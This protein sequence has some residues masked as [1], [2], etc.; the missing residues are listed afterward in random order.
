MRARR[1]LQNA[2]KV[3]IANSVRYIRHAKALAQAAKDGIRLFME[4]SWASIPE[5]LSELVPRPFIRFDFVRN[6]DGGLARAGNWAALSENPNSKEN[7]RKTMPPVSRIQIR[8][9]RLTRHSPW[10]A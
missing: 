9:P 3:V 1:A 8:G 4:D 7:G 10:P 6:Q 5:D 2:F